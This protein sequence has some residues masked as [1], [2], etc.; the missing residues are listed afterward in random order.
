M[1]PFFSMCPFSCIHF[2]VSISVN[3]CPCVMSMCPR[4]SVYMSMCPCLRPCSYSCVRVQKNFGIFL[5]FPLQQGC[6]FW[7]N[8]PSLPST[9]FG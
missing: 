1:C 5:D 6:L 7:Q 9:K 8:Q 2:H 3:P 4:Q